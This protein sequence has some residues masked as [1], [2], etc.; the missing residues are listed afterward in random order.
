MIPATTQ[1]EE[2]VNTNIWLI[3]WLIDW[4][5]GWLID[6]L[7]DWLLIARFLKGSSKNQMLATDAKD[8]LL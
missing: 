1:E 2:S 6:W 4:L 3:D 5:I 7:T 8:T